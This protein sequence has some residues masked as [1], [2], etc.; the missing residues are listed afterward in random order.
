M[1]LLSYARA[2]AEAGARL[3]AER[4]TEGHRD[5]PVQFLMHSIE[6]YLKSFLR[7]SGRTV[8]Q[9]WGHNFAWLAKEAE[10]HGLPLDDQDRYVI[11]VMVHTDAWSRSRYI[12]TGFRT[13]A[14][15]LRKEGQHV[16]PI[17]W[18]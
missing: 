8:K 9:V 12:E 13:H 7:L 5:A 10:A 16:H 6:L 2:Y 14:T 3:N 15:A 4:L 11:E 18:G 17:T 1:A